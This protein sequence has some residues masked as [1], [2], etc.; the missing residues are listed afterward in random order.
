MQIHNSSSAQKVQNKIPNLLFR[1]RRSGHEP[2]KGTTPPYG[3]H[4]TLL[5]H[6]GGTTLLTLGV[7]KHISSTLHPL[8]TDA[9]ESQKL[10][11]NGM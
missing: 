11:H 9:L 6:V 3:T 2:L 10:T 5:E 7:Y 4:S 1:F 8:T